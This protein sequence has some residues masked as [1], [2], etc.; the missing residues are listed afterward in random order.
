MAETRKKLGESAPAAAT[1]TTLYDCPAATDAVISVV[2]VCNRSS[3]PTSYRLGVDVGGTGDAD[4]Q[5]S[6][7]DVAIGAN[8]THEVMR[9]AT[10]AADDLLRCY[11]TLATVSFSAFG[12]ENA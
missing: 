7:Y 11:A 10:L 8:E 9:G 1:A 5:W 2:T 12:A 4:A 6:Y 3:T